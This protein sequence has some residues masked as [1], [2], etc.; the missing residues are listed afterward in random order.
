MAE[1]Q[2][3]LEGC[4]GEILQKEFSQTKQLLDVRDSR[5]RGVGDD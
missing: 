5:E 1:V 2:G 3:W 4:K